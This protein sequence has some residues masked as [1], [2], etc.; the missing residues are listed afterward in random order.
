MKQKKQKWKTVPLL[1][2]CIPTDHRCRYKRDGGRRCKANAQT[3]AE[4]CFFHDPA[5]VDK[6]AEARK[7]GGIARTR[8]IAPPR[9]LPTKPLQTV[10]QVVELLGQTI[11]QVRCGQ[12]DLRV[13]NAIG[14][15]S[16]ILLG[17]IEKQ[18]LEE[19]LGALEAVVVSGSQSNNVALPE[20]C[21]F[22]F[23]QANSTETNSPQ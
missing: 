7:A 4:F 22:D 15:L 2:R 14:Y 18:S 21:S 8:K 17:A 5:L 16:G 1:H 13:S 11:N 10:A 3:G 9:N 12:I 20:G 19:R 23:V 6:R